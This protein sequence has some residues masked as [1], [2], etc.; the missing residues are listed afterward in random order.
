MRADKL[1]M[2]QQIK[3]ITQTEFV[4]VDKLKEVLVEKIVN[5]PVKEFIDREVIKKVEVI[6][7]V[8]EYKDKIVEKIVKVGAE[9]IK[10]KD[11]RVQ[12]DE[13]KTED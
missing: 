4:E 6:K 8:I 12:T 13:V 2:E 11:Q 1:Y 9:Q 5:V 7:P 10:T 3:I